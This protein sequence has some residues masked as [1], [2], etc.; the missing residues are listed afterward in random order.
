MKQWVRLLEL[1]KDLSLVGC[2]VRYN[3][4]IVDGVVTSGWNRGL[5]MK[6]PESSKVTPWLAPDGTMLNS[7]PKIEVEV[8]ISPSVTD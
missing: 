5:W 8:E 4:E 6:D 1:P 7:A 3:G 2:R